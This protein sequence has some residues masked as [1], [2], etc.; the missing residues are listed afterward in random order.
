MTQIVR[1][2]LIDE[3]MDAP[4]INQHHDILVPQFSNNTNGLWVLSPLYGVEG[5]FWKGFH[6]FSFNL[7]VVLVN[8][9]A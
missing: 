4:S 2:E 1:H 9:F 7:V 3:I 6:G 5:Y 8:G